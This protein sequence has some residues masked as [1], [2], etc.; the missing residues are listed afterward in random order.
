MTAVSCVSTDQLGILGI[1]GAVLALLRLRRAIRE[2]EQDETADIQAV[3]KLLAHAKAKLQLEGEE[4]KAA[5]KRIDEMEE[6][7]I[8]VQAKIENLNM[9]SRKPLDLQTPGRAN[10]ETLPEEQGV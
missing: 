3:R 5:C 8:D 7:L 4:L 6:R 9:E 10:P 2:S 1:I